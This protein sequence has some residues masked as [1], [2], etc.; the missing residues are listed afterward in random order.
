MEGRHMR[1]LYEKFICLHKNRRT[2]CL[3]TIF[4]V[5]ALGFAGCAPDTDSLA[6]VEAYAIYAEEEEP[7]AADGKETENPVESS[8][9]EREN[10]TEQGQT[11]TTENPAQENTNDGIPAYSGEA[12]AV[13]NQNMPYFSESDDTVES[14]EDYSPLDALG[15]CGVAYAN[16]GQDIMPTEERGPIGQIKP[17]GWH[18][19]KYDVVDGN[20]LYNRCHLIGYQLSAEN[21]NER[22]LITGTRYMNVVGMVPFEN[23]VADYVKE[24]GNHV[25]YRVTPVFEG[26]NLLADGV[27]MEAKSVEDGG[28]GICFHVFVY[29]V[30]PGIGID[31]ATGDNWLE[32]EAAAVSVQAGDETAG[33][34]IQEE[35]AAPIS[36][37][38]D[39][40]LNTNTKKFHYP[41]C[42]SVGQMKEKNKQAY[43]GTREEII[44]MG[45]DP[46]QNCSP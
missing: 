45:Y 43:F 29:N 19:V 40:I 3:A 8:G 28:A 20:Y 44:G 34:P 38:A 42:A 35:E 37:A 16:I 17:S 30:Q 7:A 1:K 24:T 46:C 32:E 33:I 22:N 39:Y 18:T 36:L 25:L 23:M 27:R 9:R 15:R 5:L 31:Y 2:C 10:P 21:A 6:P 14:F 4:M 11:E 12:Y 41:S 13:I 26:D